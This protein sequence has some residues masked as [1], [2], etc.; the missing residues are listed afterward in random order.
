MKLINPGAH[1]RK[2][3][4]HYM[5]AV[6]V[7]GIILGYLA[8]RGIRNDQALREKES[9]MKLELGSQSFF[10]AINS[11]F[12]QFMNELSIDTAFSLSTKDD[13]SLLAYFVKDNKGSKRLISHRML[14][15]P[16]EFRTIQNAELS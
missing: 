7:P 15:L 6:V 14:Y 2:I 5:L 16:D 11:S 10:T 9:R 12:E 8:F 13:P 3:I 1:R 4:M